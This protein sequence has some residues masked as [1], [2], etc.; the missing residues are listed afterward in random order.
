MTENTQENILKS[1]ILLEKRGR[2][3]YKKVAKQTELPA[4][5]EFFEMMA[6]EEE[7][8]VAILAEQFRAYQES[9][10]FKSTEYGDDEAFSGVAV[11][12][13][14][15]KLKTEI[16]AADFEAAAIGAAMSMEQRAIELYA[17]RGK[18]AEDPNEVALYRWLADWERGHLT[19]LAEI[20]QELREEVWNDN[21]FWPY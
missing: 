18:E 12:V 16:S 5:R 3:F 1:A 14:S 15:E 7:T 20:D 8:H 9:G 13:L 2:A 21:N 4:V 10:H 11:K 6:A 19:F 17:N